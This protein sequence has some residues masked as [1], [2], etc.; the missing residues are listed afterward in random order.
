[1]RDGELPSTFTVAPVLAAD[2]LDVVVREKE[3]LND[4]PATVPAPV[5]AT[6]SVCANMFARTAGPVEDNSRHRICN[7]PGTDPKHPRIP[8]IVGYQGADN[9]SPISE[10]LQLEMSGID[11][12]NSENV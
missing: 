7:T 10:V 4:L 5:I 8:K 12:R 6:I 1:M 11:V 2:I 9:V 3:S